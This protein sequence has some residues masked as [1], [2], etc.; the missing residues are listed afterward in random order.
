MN[1]QSPGNGQPQTPY[2]EAPY[3][4]AGTPQQPGPRRNGGS[5][6]ASSYGR[7]D[8]EPIA[9]MSP[10]DFEKLCRSIDA[11]VSRISEAVGRGLGAAGESV[12]GIVDQAIRSYRQSHQQ[13]QG[14]QGQNTAAMVQADAQRR[15]AALAKKHFR[16]TAGATAG[17]SVLAVF[18]GGILLTSAICALV[19]L[20]IPSMP[21]TAFAAGMVSCGAGV[22]IGAGLLGG[23]ISLLRKAARL[24]SF[25]RIFGG[26]EVCT[27]D[28]LAAQTHTPPAKILADSR[29]LLKAG[30]IP[31]GHLD[32]E[33][34]CLMVTDQAYR[35]YRESQSAYQRRLE[36]QRREEAARLRA[37]GAPQD[38]TEE[39]LA[40]I[41]RGNAYLQQLRDLDVAIDD[42]E[43][44]AKINAIETVVGR[45]LDRV[46]D[47]PSVTDSL[48]KLMDY[49]LPTTVKLLMAYN[50]LEDQPIQGD[51][52]ASSRRE[53]EQTLDVLCGAYEKLLDS[54][55][56]DLSMDVS[57]DISVLHAM[58]AQEG[59][60]EDPFA[61]GKP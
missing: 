5:C 48:D 37:Q 8:N 55:F 39:S 27:I 18:G 9:G 19:A 31:Q 24:K 41:E 58:L 60:T 3:G 17:G 40:L 1:S 42:T 54:T 45:I 49:Y 52:I 43:V 34:T 61:K 2:N 30:L 57:S 51:T 53:I 28:E 29:K 4:G 47:E 7:N 35:H 6:S 20:A 25:R 10:E 56:R 22:L 13:K 36:A 16:S 14:H 46:R 21:G 23:G 32:D 59:L 50:D 26:R 38:P 44:S 11:T 15:Q 12:G 33:G